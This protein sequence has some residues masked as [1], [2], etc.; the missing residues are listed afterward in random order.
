LE[1]TIADDPSAATPFAVADS[2]MPVSDPV[3]TTTCASSTSPVT[4]V[5]E[6]V[7]EVVPPS[8]A[9]VPAGKGARTVAAI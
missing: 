3:E 7:A 4:T 5:T 2:D 9:T 1:W 8:V 6:V